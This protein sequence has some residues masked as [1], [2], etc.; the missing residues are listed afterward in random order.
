ME[1]D[2]RKEERF[3][4]QQMIGYGP[5]REEYLWAEGVDLSL[6][7]MSCITTR[8]VDP[9]TELYI[10]IDIPAEGRWKQVRVEGYIAHVTLHGDFY[11]FG[12]I[13]T[14]VSD[15]DRE[16]LEAY[17]DK[18]TPIVDPDPPFNDQVSPL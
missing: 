5:G 14:D 6:S 15:N 1:A 11:H 10:M 7:G 16:N 8:P 12:V 4:I 2:R 13:F 3:R 9:L 18:L 17:L